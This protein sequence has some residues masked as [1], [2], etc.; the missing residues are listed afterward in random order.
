MNKFEGTFQ[1]PVIIC[2]HQLEILNFQELARNL[3]NRLDLNIEMYTHANSNFYINIICI[4]GIV[5]KA[6]LKEIKSTLLPEIRYE[7]KSNDVV[8]I[9]YGDFIEIVFELTIDY[10][11]LLELNEKDELKEIKLFKTLFKQLQLLGIDEILFG[12]FDEFELGENVKFNWENAYQT[13][14]KCENYFEVAFR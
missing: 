5:E 13:M 3:S 7:F 4:D 6:Q 1:H 11:H 12:I 2:K 9:I 14:L 10:F 8:L